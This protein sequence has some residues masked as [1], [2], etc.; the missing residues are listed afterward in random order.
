MN[1]NEGEWDDY[2]ALKREGI[3]RRLMVAKGLFS[4]VHR[5]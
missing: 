1:A 2:V 5:K 3:N 4:K